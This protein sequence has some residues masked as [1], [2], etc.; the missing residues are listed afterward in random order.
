M[1]SSQNNFSTVSKMVK[2]CTRL[3]YFL[4]VSESVRMH[5]VVINGSIPI[6]DSYNSKC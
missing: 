1:R 4:R 2:H 6:E 5:L 3:T